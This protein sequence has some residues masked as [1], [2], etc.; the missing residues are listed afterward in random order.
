MKLAKIAL[1]ALGLLASIS[2]YARDTQL[3]FEGGIGVIPTSRVDPP[4]SPATVPTVVRNDVRGLQPGGQPWVIA[5]LDARIRPDGSIRVEGRG[6]LLAGGNGIGTNG[7]QSVRAVLF[8]GPAASASRHDSELVALEPDGDF[9]IGGELSP[10]PPSPCENPVLLIVN[11]M[12][13]W[14]AAGILED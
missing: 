5:R 1:V 4:V 9:R 6:L 11:P 2:A 12:D 7:G 10:L 13:R 8:C 14:F 3:R